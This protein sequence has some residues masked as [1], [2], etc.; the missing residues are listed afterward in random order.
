MNNK[1]INKVVK[2]A[3]GYVKQGYTY[4]E[5]IKLAQQ[6]VEKAERERY[7]GNGC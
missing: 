4:T 1:K 6:D 3:K 5:A 2:R 7:E